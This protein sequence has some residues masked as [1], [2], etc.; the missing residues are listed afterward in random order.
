MPGTG[1]TVDMWKHTATIASGLVFQNVALTTLVYV[2]VADS[3]HVVGSD[4]GQGLSLTQDLFE[5]MRRYAAHHQN[6]PLSVLLARL[7]TELNGCRDAATQLDN[8]VTVLQAV[9]DLP[10]TR[11]VQAAEWAHRLCQAVIN[12]LKFPSAASAQLKGAT[13][14]SARRLGS[15]LGETLKT[16][17]LCSGGAT[18]IGE[19]VQS[20]RG[21]HT[22]SLG[23]G[24]SAV[25]QGLAQYP[26]AAADLAELISRYQS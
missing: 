8:A 9:P 3:A 22:F 13:A 10:S 24:I 23:D 15:V 17:A 25:E 16:A 21:Q 2:H 14:A 18:V 6:T 12:G 26:Q 11:T 1:G 4:L 5:R 19:D 20:P 7:Y